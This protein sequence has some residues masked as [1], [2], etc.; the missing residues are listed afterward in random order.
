MDVKMLVATLPDDANLAGWCRRLGI[1]R[2][3]AYKWRDRYRAEGAAGLADRSR[4]PTTPAGRTR[5][6]V[7]DRVVA[8]RKRLCEQGLDHGPASVRDYLAG[9]GGPVLSDSTVWRILTRRGQ[10]NAQPA[11]RPRSSW[12]RWE[13][14]RPNECWQGDDTHYLLAD[15][16]ELR[17]INLLDDCSRVNT[18]S[19]AVVS[20]RSPQVLEAFMRAVDRYG[21]PAE[22]LSDNGRAWRSAAGDAANVFQAAL[23][24]LNV[25][26]IH[27]SPYHPQT[28]GKVE[29]FHQTQRRWLDARPPAATIDQAQTLLDEFRDIYNTQ[30]THRGIGRRVP[31][32]VWSAQPPAAPPVTAGTPRLTI[33]RCTS[34]RNG[35]I[36]AGAHTRI[37]LGT[38]WGGR[39]VTVIRRGDHATVFDDQTGAII[40][41]LTIDRSRNFQKTGRPRGGPQRHKPQPNDM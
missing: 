14:E 24:R 33:A 27:S 12:R 1:S 22:F 31:A 13:R 6:E 4:A 40:R 36:S 23:A 7:E 8:I 19:L 25:R 30:R 15:G 11:K 5:A 34:Y 2:P 28:C 17:V 21:V 41:E 37:G 26:D 18:D 9:E 10:V 29:R 16:Q 32:Q 39:R 3:T 35:I 20:C 38:E